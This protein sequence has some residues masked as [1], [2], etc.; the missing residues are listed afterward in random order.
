[1]HRAIERG[2]LAAGLAA[3]ALFAA[4]AWSANA[5][6]ARDASKPGARD[7]S[8]RPACATE[9][10]KHKPLAGC[11]PLHESEDAGKA[12]GVKAGEPAWTGAEGSAQGPT[13]GRDRWVAGDRHV[14]GNRERVA[15]SASSS[16]D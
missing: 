4:P 2:G 1:M 7:G 15:G 13:Q 3:A 12:G 9:D 14:D 10:A 16:L 6:S 11:L 8:A 5:Q